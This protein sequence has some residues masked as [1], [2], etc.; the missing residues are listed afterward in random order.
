MESQQ[1]GNINNHH[2]YEVMGTVS[3]IPHPT[4]QNVTYAPKEW[5]CNVFENSKSIHFRNSSEKHVDII[6][7]GETEKFN[8][9][10]D[11]ERPPYYKMEFSIQSDKVKEITP[12]SDKGKI[13]VTFKVGDKIQFVIDRDIKCGLSFS[14]LGKHIIELDKEELLDKEVFENKYFSQYQS[15]TIVPEPTND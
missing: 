9:K 8:I 10:E 1:N 5:Y 2:F 15:Y 6:I 14:V 4:K 7:F 13:Y 12:L 11:D 3:S